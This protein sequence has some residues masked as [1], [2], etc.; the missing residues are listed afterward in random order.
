M[1]EKNIIN[2]IYLTNEQNNETN[3]EPIKEANKTVI[4]ANYHTKMIEYYM[5]H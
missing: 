3:K 5:I 4:K 1:V 2:I